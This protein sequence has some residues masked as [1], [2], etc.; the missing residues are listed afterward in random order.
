[1][2]VNEVLAARGAAERWVSQADLD[3]VDVPATALSWTAPPTTSVTF[4]MTF[5]EWLHAIDL[6]GQ[7]RRWIGRCLCRAAGGS[8]HQAATRSVGARKR[9]ARHQRSHQLRGRTRVLG[10]AFHPQFATNGRFFV[11]YTDVNGNSVI[12]EFTRA[13]RGDR[14]SELREGDPHAG[15]AIPEPQRRDARVRA[16]RIPVHRLWRRRVAGATAGN[17]Q[18]L[19]TSSG[20]ILRIDVD[21]DRTPYGIPPTTRSARQ[22]A[23]RRPRSGT[24]G[25]AIRGASRSIARPGDLFIGDVGQN[26]TRRDRR[27]AG[28]HRAAATTA[29]T[30]WKATT[31]TTTQPMRSHGLTLPVADDSHDGGNC[32]VTGGYVYRGTRY[33]SLVGRYFFA[34]YCSGN[35]WW[36][37]ADA[38]RGRARR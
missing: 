14:G 32:S 16:G 25:C 4:A 11:D 37:D 3:D 15:A 20:K 5:C 1:M 35:V 29:G 28:R 13:R 6:R 36:F 21:S 18:N 7:C 8:G 2:S 17:G 26:H 10:L 34:D 23:G 19:S 30:S 33:P 31:A 22:R 12:S 24:R 27:R 38:G 9:L